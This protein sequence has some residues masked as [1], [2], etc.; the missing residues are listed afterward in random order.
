MNK[1]HLGTDHAG[2]KLKESLK[3]WLIDLG[4]EVQDHGAYEYNSNDDYPDFIT[5]VAREISKEPKGK[6]IILGGSG[7]GEAIVANRFPFVRAC[8]YYGPA[9]KEQ[10]DSRGE[11]LDLIT[12]ARRHDD[13]NMLSLGARF[14]DITEAKKVVQIFLETE[15]LGDERHV[16]RI[17]KIDS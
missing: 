14:I 7:Q 2:Y 8:V 3:K 4:Y 1:V 13:C 10:V 11:H 15:F 17:S 9:A 5:K 16:R 12:S 6:A